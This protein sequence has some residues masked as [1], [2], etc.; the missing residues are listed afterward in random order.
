MK[1]FSLGLENVTRFS[2]A[3]NYVQLST[4]SPQ[5]QWGSTTETECASWGWIAALHSAKR[6]RV[7]FLPAGR[8]DVGPFAA[9]T[10]RNW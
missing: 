2:A 7:G 3:K 1:C 8:E 9:E 4:V 6:A 10:W 5:L